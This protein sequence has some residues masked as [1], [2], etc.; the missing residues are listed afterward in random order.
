MFNKLAPN[1]KKFLQAFIAAIIFIYIGIAFLSIDL[2]KNKRQPSDPSLVAQTAPSNTSP[3]PTIVTTGIYLDGIESFSIRDSSWSGTFFVWFRW[4]GGK[5][6][7]P[8]KTFQLVDAKID[9]KELQDSFVSE[10][11]THYQCYKIMAKMMKFF[12]TAF[13]PLDE[14]TLS[15]KIEDAAADSSKLLYVPDSSSNISANIRVPSFHV[16]EFNQAAN[17][18]IYPTTYGDPR[19]QSGDYS[20]YSHYSY[21]LKIKRNGL[22]FFFKLFLGMFAGVTLALASFFIRPQ[23]IGPRIALPSASYFG[24]IGN[25]YMVSTITPPSGQFDLTDLVTGIG[26]LT[27]T[28]CVGVTLLSTYYY[29]RKEEKEFS[30][31]IDLTSFI[32]LSSCYLIIN[33][34]LI[35]FTLAQLS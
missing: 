7:D 25:M 9:K 6:I 30:K 2:L 33:G 24:A 34:I 28:L 16:T 31:C 12:N 11:G 29:I 14:H 13:L 1:Q 23:D 10:D 35:T 27:V 19:L 21:N 18:H 15:I 32:C 17:T 4:N 5:D 26:F 20:E 3:P 22:N 8:G